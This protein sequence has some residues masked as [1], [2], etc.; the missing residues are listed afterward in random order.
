MPKIIRI[1]AI[2]KRS[3]YL[4]QK[5][6]NFELLTKCQW[7]IQPK[8]KPTTPLIKAGQETITLSAID[9]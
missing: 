6:L 3:Q 2:I 8:V 7:V 1:V 5:L 9:G 4:L